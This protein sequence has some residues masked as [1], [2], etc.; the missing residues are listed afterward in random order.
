MNRPPMDAREAQLAS[1]IEEVTNDLSVAP[2][3]VVLRE[4]FFVNVFLQMF[5][6]KPD[7]E[8]KVSPHM[9]ISAAKGPFNEVTVVDNQGHFLYDVPAYFSDKAI[10]PLDGTGK[11]ARMPTV[12]DMISHAKQYANRG[13]AV[14][15]GFILQELDNRSFMFNKGVDNSETIARWN[16]IFARYGIKPI[17]QTSTVNQHAANPDNIARDSTDFDLLE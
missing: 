12:T 2:A 17:G 15:E 16:A 7:K 3:K 1:F 6:G 10:K 11:D 5:A 14:V 8:T 4:D 13:A 9:W